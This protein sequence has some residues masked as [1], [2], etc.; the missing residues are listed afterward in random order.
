MNSKNST[1]HP[2]AK[3]DA[4]V[5]RTIP[6]YD[7]F[8]QETISIIKAMQLEPQN[9][10]DTGCGTGT[11]AEKALAAFPNTAFVLADP[12]NEMLL[13]SKKKLANV[14]SDRVRFLEPAA[15][16]DLVKNKERF[17]VITAIQAHH[18]LSRDER[19]KA[20]LACF[21][22]LTQSGVYV[23]FENIRPFT[24]EG[25]EIG[26][27]YWKLFQLSQGRNEETVEKHLKR[28]DS[29]YF[30]ITIEEHLSLLR[31]AGFSTVEMLWLSYLQAGFYCIK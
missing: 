5:G 13:E 19:A 7:L 28:F 2:A 14:P 18:Y 24:K 6:Y 26:K 8:H 9:W 29:E 11:F 12:S 30:P 23:T 21:K 10:L 3:Y 17:Q 22:L 16:Q 25:T 20:T 27:K 15:T 4:E 31:K 1:P